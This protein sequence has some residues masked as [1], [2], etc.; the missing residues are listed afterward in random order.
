MKSW[1]DRSS[2]GGSYKN[3]PSGYGLGGS[4]GN[5]LDSTK[6]V[7]GESIK[8]G[9]MTP[10]GRGNT[11]LIS[12]ARGEG[13]WTELEMDDDSSQKHIIHRKIEVTVDVSGGRSIS[14]VV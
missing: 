14:R 7:K 12:A 2:K 10:K 3:N 5:G 1:I 4:S 9:Y 8:M 13:K 11:T 6:K